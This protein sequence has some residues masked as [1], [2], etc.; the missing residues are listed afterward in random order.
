MEIL[1]SCLF[2]HF[3]KCN[4]IL[5]YLHHSL[6]SHSP[7]D[8]WPL[9]LVFIFFPP[10]SPPL[11]SSLPF[12]HP[13]FMDRKFVL[14]ITTTWLLLSSLLIPF[15][16]PYLFLLWI[17]WTERER[18]NVCVRAHDLMPTPSIISYI[19]IYSYELQL[20]EIASS[21]LSY[22]FTLFVFLAFPHLKLRTEPIHGCYPR[23]LVFFKINLSISFEYT[24]LWRNTYLFSPIRLLP[25]WISLELLCLYLKVP[26]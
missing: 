9:I 11:S 14:L 15:S 25:P 10:E 4:G 19:F 22:F 21:T 17:W 2:R 8:L 16:H 13:L 1:S 7:L 24:R 23:P 6:F 26:I 5:L 12:P 18:E 20:G 3:L